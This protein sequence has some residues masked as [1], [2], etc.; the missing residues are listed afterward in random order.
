MN[1]DEEYKRQLYIILFMARKYQ[2][3][4]LRYMPEYA[5]VLLI[6]KILDLA[7][8]DREGLNGYVISQDSI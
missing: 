5:S 2:T 7:R 4:S 3:S 6:D 8:E 1:S